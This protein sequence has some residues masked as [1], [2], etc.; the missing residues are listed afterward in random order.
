MSSCKL[1]C[2]CLL[3]LAHIVELVVLNGFSLVSAS[4]G[5]QSDNSRAVKL[6]KI[7]L[8]SEIDMCLNGCIYKYKSASII[9]SV[10]LS[11]EVVQCVGEYM[12]RLQV[13]I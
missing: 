9:K 12:L 1:S 7:S 11:R 2:D 3:R 5:F 13:N 6:F 8:S 10:L 4:R